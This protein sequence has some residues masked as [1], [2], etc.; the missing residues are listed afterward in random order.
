MLAPQ[1]VSSQTR[2]ISVGVKQVEKCLW[3]HK[4]WRKNKK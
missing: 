2:D 3:G 4:H 1:F